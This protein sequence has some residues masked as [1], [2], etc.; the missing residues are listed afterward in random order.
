ML[1]VIDLVVGKKELVGGLIHSL[2][3]KLRRDLLT[4]YSILILCAFLPP[5]FFSRTKVSERVT[6]QVKRCEIRQEC[7]G[8]SDHVPIVL[9]IA[10]DA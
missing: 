8:A 9:E 10:L 2:Y 7:Y 4:N 3:A 5:L 6:A 1:L